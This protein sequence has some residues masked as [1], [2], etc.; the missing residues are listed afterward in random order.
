MFAYDTTVLKSGNNTDW[1]IK[2]DLQKITDWFIASKLTKNICR[3][4]VVS[5]GCGLSEKN[6]SKRRTMLQ[7]FM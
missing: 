7:I 2:E 6:Y 1:K 3:C 5:F 4:E